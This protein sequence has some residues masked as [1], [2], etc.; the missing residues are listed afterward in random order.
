MTSEDMDE[1]EHVVR[2]P[3]PLQLADSFYLWQDFEQLQ[4]LHMMPHTTHTTR[5]LDELLQRDRLREEDGFPRKIRLGKLI[6]PG[7]GGRD[8]IVVVPS[9]TEEKFYH[10]T[11]PPGDDSD[12]TGEGEQ[13]AGMGDGDVGEVIGEQP[14]H[15]AEGQGSGTGP[16]DGGGGNHE[17]GS[18]AY[19]LGRLLT[20]QLQLPNLKDKGKKRSLTRFSYDL[21]DKNRGDGQILDKKAT[22]KQIIRTNIGLGRLAPAAPIDPTGLLVHNRDRI[23]RVLSRERDFESQAVVFFVR[24]YSGSMHGKPTEAVVT[25][26]VLIYSWLM[27]QYQ[28]QVET[29]FI[30]HDTDAKE[31]PDFYTYSHSTVAGGTKVAAALTLVNQIVDSEQLARDNNI[32]V[33]YGGDGDDWESDGKECI[34]AMR[35]MLGYANRVGIIISRNATSA[36]SLERYLKKSSLCDDFSDELRLDAFPANSAEERIIQSIRM[37]VS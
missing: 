36:P 32:Y 12:Q 7:K 15:E 33:F 37:L 8:R 26:H 22:L 3:Q 19:E 18:D 30:L 10:D 24:D 31:V 25:Q 2:E 17:L 21:T 5:T 16:G 27:Y 34:A 11:R 35:H 14:I 13:S 9:A 28:A 23:Y 1:R 20:E 4:N 29:R 6:R